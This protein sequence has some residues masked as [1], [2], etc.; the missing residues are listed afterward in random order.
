MS[1]SPVSSPPRLEP[2]NAGFPADQAAEVEE[3]P[4]EDGPGDDE[5]VDADEVGDEVR[6]SDG[7]D[8]GADLIGFVVPPGVPVSQG[9]SSAGEE[10]AVF[11]QA[12]QSSADDALAL[13]ENP[14][15]DYLPP[16]VIGPEEHEEADDD[17]DGPA[18]NDADN[19]EED[20]GV[21]SDLGEDVAF[22]NFLDDDVL[23]VAAHVAEHE[24]LHGFGVD[25][26]IIVSSDE[27]DLDEEDL[28]APEL[29][30]ASGK[31]RSTFPLSDCSDFTITAVK[32]KVCYV[33]G[34]GG[35]SFPI[36]MKKSKN[37]L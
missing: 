37:S 33:K 9:T 6:S 28:A 31:R 21:T 19:V 22:L 30:T 5:P 11:S 23:E 3:D 26:H 14:D 32:R 29:V 20:D 24:E 25:T 27:E 7:E 2:F 15:G 16:G 1:S 36:F 13:E 35:Q 10:S 18:E 8:N 34:T 12:T 17:D 4:E